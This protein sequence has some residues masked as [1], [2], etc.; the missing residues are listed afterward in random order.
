MGPNVVERFLVTGAQGF[1]GA[2]ILK[3]LISEGVPLTVIDLDTNPRRLRQIATE[4]EI[5]RVDFVRGD[6]SDAP[7][8]AGLVEERGITHIIHLAGLQ[9]P[10]CQ[11]DPIA[12]ATVNVIGTLAVFEAAR[13][14]PEQVQRIVYASS[15]GVFGEIDAYQG[16]VRDDSRPTPVSHYSV[17]KLTN[18]GNARIYWREHQISSIGLR[19]LTVY[20]PGRDQGLTSAPT[21]AMKAAVVRRPFTIPFSGS[22]DMLYVDDCAKAFIRCARVPFQGAEVYN[23]SGELVDIVDIVARIEEILPEAQGLIRVSGDLMPFY[24][25]V[26]DSRLRA[27]IGVHERTSLRAGVAQTIL[28]FQESQ[29][30]GGLDSRELD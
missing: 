25:V 15:I 24:P 21:K 7:A 26:D 19:P 29:R 23:V 12:G 13:R 3:N 22:T 17:F 30:A 10:A 16:A 1:I 18:E 4:A 20:G 5:A 27:L 2:W 6:I 14:F 28:H 8:V 9:T 11:A